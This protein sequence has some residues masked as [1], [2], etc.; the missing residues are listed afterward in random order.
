MSSVNNQ[1]KVFAL[2]SF[3]IWPIFA[4][5]IAI[6]SYKMPWAKNI[7]WFFTIFYAFTLVISNEE[8]DANRYRD[9]FL[10]I[11]TSDASAKE[12]IGRIYSTTNDRHRQFDIVRPI[13]GYTVSRFTYDHRILFAIYGLIF[14]Y[15]YSRNI[16]FLLDRSGPKLKPY[17]V[18]IIFTFAIIVGFWQINGFRFWTATHI[19]LFGMLNY[20]IDG[21]IKGVWI[22][23]SSIAVHFSFL[24]PV[25]ILL[26]YLIIG[27]QKVVYFYFFL[28]SLLVT[29]IDLQAFRETFSFLP[30]VFQH[31][32]KGYTREEYANQISLLRSE[33]NWYAQL[34]TRALKVVA[35]LYILYLY[36]RGTSFLHKDQ[37]IAKLFNFTLLFYG[38]AN[39]ASVIPSGNRFT[40][41]G[42]LLIFAL[43]FWNLQ[44]LKLSTRI[45]QL[46]W[47]SLPPIFLFS[48]VEIRNSFDTIGLFTLLANPIVVPFLENEIALIELIK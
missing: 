2:L 30:D 29:E 40:Y 46:F 16:W 6:R 42:N 17:S 4:L 10:E 47:I 21:K 35:I 8:M 18:P 11:A 45:K 27:D 33:M 9:N 12:I 26:C 3:I 20:F 7:I 32:L 14:G 43:L 1:N 34:Y 31:K 23:I 19:F 36:N 5:I 39:I 22:A 41:L 15:F 24:F 28:V 38:F 13:I 25:A 48:L 44:M 37:G